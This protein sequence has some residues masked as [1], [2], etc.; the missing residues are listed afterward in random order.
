MVGI[1]LLRGVTV[2]AWHPLVDVLAREVPEAADNLCSYYLP[3]R[4]RWAIALWVNRT[5]GIVQELLSWGS[6]RELT[7]SRVNFLRYYLSE[8]RRDDNFR[9]REKQAS[10]RRADLRRQS[11][12]L[13]AKRDVRRHYAGKVRMGTQKI[14]G[15]E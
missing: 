9:Y 13:D 15:L 4:K 1:P 6:E 10:D 8:K 14:K 3:K 11:D 12:V 5:A 2:L 7:R